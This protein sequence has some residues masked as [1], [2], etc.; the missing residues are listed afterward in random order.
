MQFEGID[1]T[2]LSIYFE[3]V[4]Q[5]YDGGQDEKV[6]NL[7]K[8]FLR[9][10]LMSDREAEVANGIRQFLTKLYKNSIEHKHN[11]P[12]WKG[13]LEVNDD[14]TLIKYTILLLEHMW[15]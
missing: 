6:L 3:V 15:Y 13:L 12:I 7:T 9:S 4:E 11:A 2:E 14:F 10:T 5:N 1:W 8:D